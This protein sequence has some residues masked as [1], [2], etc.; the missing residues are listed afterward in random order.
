MSQISIIV[1]PPENTKEALV[2]AGHLLLRGLSTE[3]GMT[4]QAA[5]DSIVEGKH[6]F[7]VV[8]DGEKIIGAFLTEVFNEGDQRTLDVGALAGERI[9]SWGKAI[10]REMVRFANFTGAS[11]IIFKGRKGLLRAYEGF[12]I[13]GEDSP[14]I[15]KFERAVT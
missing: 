13:V 1:V 11:R 14:G 3:H 6:Q 10:S 9:L 15:F 12:T 7:W 5:I 8:F 2:A 4:L